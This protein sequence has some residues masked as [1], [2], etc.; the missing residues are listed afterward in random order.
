MVNAGANDEGYLA[1]SLGQ[2][3]LEGSVCALCQR[4]R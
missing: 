3:R 2:Q 1:N 4:V